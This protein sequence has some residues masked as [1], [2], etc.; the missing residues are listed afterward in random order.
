M[1]S[2]FKPVALLLFLALFAACPGFAQ[3]RSEL[4]QKVEEAKSQGLPQT[5]I[6]HLT[7]IYESAIKEGHMVDAVRALCER[8]VQEG[9]IQG[10]QPQEKIVRL[11]QEIE[12]ADASIKPL[13]NIILAK[14]YWHFYNRNSYRFMNRSRTE[15]LNEKD[16]TT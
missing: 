2:W 13:L 7:P 16:F 4:W 3:S 9:T 11:E 15:G 14:W 8:I 5:A 6:E 1:K 12:K 10:N